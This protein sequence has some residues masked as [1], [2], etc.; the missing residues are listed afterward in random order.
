V[1]P[2]TAEELTK[3]AARAKW[4]FI[5]GDSKENGYQIG[6]FVEYGSNDEDIT[7]AVHLLTHEI[8]DARK[9]VDHVLDDRDGSR[10]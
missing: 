10:S 7:A 3:R 9:R 2:E 4:N 5:L 8:H 1:K 6:S